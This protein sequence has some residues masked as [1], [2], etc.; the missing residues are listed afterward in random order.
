M[1]K[2]FDVNV[3]FLPQEITNCVGVES[4]NINVKHVNTP[5]IGM[6]TIPNSN[7]VNAQNQILHTHEFHS[8]RQKMNNECH[9]I[10]DDAIV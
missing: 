1:T 3:H 9:L 2:F 10:S 6:S 5:H 4:Y 8:L 7:N